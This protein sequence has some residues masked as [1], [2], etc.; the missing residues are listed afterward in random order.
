MHLLG[1]RRRLGRQDAKTVPR[2]VADSSWMTALM[3]RPLLRVG[4]F[5]LRGG[6]CAGPTR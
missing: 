4:G 1:V 3:K 2:W 6:P 5:R